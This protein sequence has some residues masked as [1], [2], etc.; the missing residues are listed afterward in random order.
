MK[1]LP[2]SYEN[3]LNGECWTF[4]KFSILSTS[5]IAKPWLATHI[6]FYINENMSG[7]YGDSD[8]DYY[9]MRYYS[10]VLSF[11]RISASDTTPEK[12]VR[13]IYDEIEKDRYVV[14]YLN[15]NRLYGREG[16]SLHE[17]LVYGYDDERKIC[18]CPFLING[19]FKEVEIP[20]DLIQKGYEDARNLYLADGW[21]LLVNR[22]FYFGITSLKIRDDYRNDNWVADYIDKIDHEIQGKRIIQI[23]V[24]TKEPVERTIYTGNA[25]LN[26]LS[27]FFEKFTI[28][29]LVPDN[30]SWRLIRTL[31][32]MHDYR[33]LFVS[34]IEWFVQMV[35]GGNNKALLSVLSEYK[36]CSDSVQ[37]CY[38]LLCKYTQTKDIHLIESIKNTLDELHQKERSILS[39]YR[40]L[41]WPYYYEMNGVSMPPEDN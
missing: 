31:K 12:I 37:R 24:R 5:E 10:D 9:R 3:Q 8:G 19:K 17:L 13:V 15:F 34:S 28:D 20:F 21:Q 23:D 41:I 16:V 4:Y 22:S 2:I 35:N 25:S 39:D 26:G 40:E 33:T 36:R 29:E 18:Y 7:G 11:E 1:K 38:L 6:E 32:M 30:V 27:S 14:L